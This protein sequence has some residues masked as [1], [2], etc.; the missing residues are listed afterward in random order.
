M[1]QVEE[2]NDVLPICPHCAKELTKIWRRGLES[3]FGKRYIYFCPE[4]KK[5]L[6][7]SHRKGFWM[8]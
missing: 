3:F 6:G 7:V 8:G 2:K 5:V 4:C 1:L